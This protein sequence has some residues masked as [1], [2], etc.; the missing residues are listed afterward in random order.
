MKKLSFTA[1]AL[2][3]VLVAIPASAATLSTSPATVNVVAGQTFSLPITVDSAGAS[4]VTVKAQL[5]YPTTLV[6]ATGF[7]FASGWMQLAQPG[8]DQMG[9]GVLIKTAGF[10]GG[11]VGTK[12]LGTVTFTA[13]QSGTATISISNASQVLNNQSLNVLT[14]STG[15]TLSIA[16]ATTPTTPAANPGTGAGNQG[17]GASSNTG[18]GN[19]AGVANA[20]TDEE[21]APSD[22]FAVEAGLGTS[23]DDLA[24][25]GAATGAWGRFKANWWWIV[26]LLLALG[27]TW[28]FTRTPNTEA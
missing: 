8:Y 6:D 2:L 17:A 9:N 20:L 4:V 3:F 1:A 22:E 12:I 13:K 21:V 5:S 15:T 18:A 14:G 27:A 26:L 24:A 11:F 19:T 25:A 28:W 16:G 23:S 7:S 10:P